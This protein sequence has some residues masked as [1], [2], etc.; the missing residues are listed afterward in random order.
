MAKINLLPWRESLRQKQKQ[1]YLTSLG[2]LAILVFGMFWLVGEV[3]DCL[4]YTSDAADDL[5]RS[6]LAL[7]PLA[8]KHTYRFLVKPLVCPLPHR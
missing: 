5:T 8:H 3:L 4:L 2:L 1:Q 6:P 7:A